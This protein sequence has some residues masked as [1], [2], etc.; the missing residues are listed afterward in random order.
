MYLNILPEISLNANKFLDFETDLG[1]MFKYISRVKKILALL[2]LFGLLF[3]N[4]MIR[5]FLAHSFY[6]LSNF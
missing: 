1:G 2:W 3:A 4:A 6:G 5:N